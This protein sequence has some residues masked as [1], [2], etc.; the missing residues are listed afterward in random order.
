M[1]TNSDAESGRNGGRV[2][3]L[4]IKSGTNDFHGSLYYFNRNEFLAARNWFVSPSAATQK[5]RNSEPGGSLGGPI[6]QNHTFF[7]ADFE[8]IRQS[9]G[10]TTVATVP[11]AAGFCSSAP[12]RGTQSPFAF[13]MACRSSM[14]GFFSGA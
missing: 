12:P 11:S 14:A 6:W 5:L 10:I 3:N 9:K 13:N 2:L 7:F 4:V 8:A 1:Q